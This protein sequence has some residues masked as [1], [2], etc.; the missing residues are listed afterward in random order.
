MKFLLAVVVLTLVVYALI[1]CARTS[2]SEVRVMPKV[3]WFLVIVFVP[4][5]GAAAWLLVGRV[6]GSATPPPR[7]SRPVAPDDDPD[8]LWRLEQDRRRRGAGGT[9]GTG[10]GT[11]PV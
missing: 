2:A 8:F 1:D 6:R 3:V 11:E 7:R 4:A 9:Q 5:V 10:P